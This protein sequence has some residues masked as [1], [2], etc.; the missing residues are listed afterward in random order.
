MTDRGGGCIQSGVTGLYFQLTSFLHLEYEHHII[1]ITFL[2]HDGTQLDTILNEAPLC[3]GCLG[4]SRW[5]KVAKIQDLHLLGLSTTLSWIDC[6]FSVQE[7]YG[8]NT[9]RFEAPPQGDIFLRF[10]SKVNQHIL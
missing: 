3:M 2:S 7:R 6:F 9:E 8:D 1:T 4:W 10:T 5:S